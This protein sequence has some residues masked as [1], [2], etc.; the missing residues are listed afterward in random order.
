MPLFECITIDATRKSIC[1]CFEFL[2]GEEEEH[3]VQSLEHL[4]E[5]LGDEITSGRGVFLTDKAN[6]IRNAVAR[7][8]FLFIFSI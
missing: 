3:V 6:V 7:S 1:V 4:K 5:M 2:P 8:K